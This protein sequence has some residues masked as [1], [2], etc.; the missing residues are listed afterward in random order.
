MRIIILFQFLFISVMTF[1]QITFQKTYG[2]IEAEDELK[3]R[4]LMQ[5][6]RPMMAGT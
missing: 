2:G 4:M 6:F 5:S 3:L 1:P